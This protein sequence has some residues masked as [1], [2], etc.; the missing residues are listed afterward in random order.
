MRNYQRQKNNPYKLP[1]NLYMRMLYLVRDYERIRSER[2]DILG[3]SPPADGL[4]NSALG[5]PTEQKA[6]RLAMLDRE[7]EAVSR[8][9]GTV[10]E[11][12][13]RGILNNICYGSPYPYTAH[14][15]T[16][17][18]WRTRLLNNIAKNLGLI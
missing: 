14:R 10:P 4:P 17:S 5:N 16:Y 12:Y 3:A 6:I 7:C 2:E 13:R 9:L 1:H 15:N 18:Y 8:A 11:E